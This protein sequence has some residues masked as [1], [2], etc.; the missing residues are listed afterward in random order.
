MGFEL[1]CAPFASL[2]SPEVMIH[3]LKDRIGRDKIY[4]MSDGSIRQATGNSDGMELASYPFTWEWYKNKGLNVFEDMCLKL[5]EYGWGA[6][7]KGLGIHIHTTKKAWGSYQIYKLLKFFWNNKGFVQTIA[8]RRQT[9][10]CNWNNIDY[11]NS[12]YIAKNKRNE[13]EGHYN[14]INLNN[15]DTGRSG[16]TIEFRIF[17]AT[18][19]PLYFHKN[20][21][22][23]YACYLFTQKYGNSGMTKAN[24]QQFV[25]RRQ[26]QFPCLHEYITIYNKGE[27]ICV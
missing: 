19:E 27:C 14:A 21:E 20:I 8:Q 15:G 10:Y 9:T 26:R 5:R 11:D 13:G 25:N 3:L 24:F 18:C 4:A 1:E 23:V 22:F 12:L 6:N 7:I 17:Q 2:T 16:K